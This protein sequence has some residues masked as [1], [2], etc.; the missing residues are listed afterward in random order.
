MLTGSRI[1]WMKSFQQPDH[2]YTT[3]GELDLREREGLE[4]SIIV[5]DD[6][7]EFYPYQWLLGQESDE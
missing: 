2:P 6:E 4:D 7:W 5:L 1:I 3:Q